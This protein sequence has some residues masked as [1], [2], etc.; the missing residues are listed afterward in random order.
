MRLNTSRRP[1]NWLCPKSPILTVPL[2]LSSTFSGLTSPCTCGARMCGGAPRWCWLKLGVGR[3]PAAAGMVGESARTSSCCLPTAAAP[4]PLQA[5]SS[6]Q[7][8]QGAP[9]GG[10]AGRP[11]PPPSGGSSTAE[12]DM[13][14]RRGAQDRRQLESNHHDCLL[15]GASTATA[16]SAAAAHAT[17]ARAP[18]PPAR[19][20][21]PWPP[22]G[23]APGSEPPGPPAPPPRSTPS[24]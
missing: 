16:C 3:G 21:G 10:R 14:R 1:K 7:A 2:P 19:P 5:R 18:P 15:P 20:P 17:A 23:G 22:A 11:A 13:N 6:R 4:R 12:G 8:P 9:R 24:P